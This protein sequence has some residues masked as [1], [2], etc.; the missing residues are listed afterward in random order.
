MTQ[1]P[2]TPRDIAWNAQSRLCARYCTMQEAEATEEPE[3]AELAQ[4]N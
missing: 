2:A 4:A 3:P 1:H